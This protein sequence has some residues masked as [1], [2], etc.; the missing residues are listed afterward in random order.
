[1]NIEQGAAY[2]SQL[3]R[4]VGAVHLEAKAH[5]T[6]RIGCVLLHA[7]VRCLQCD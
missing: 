7:G 1:M 5:R 3:V 6:D 4:Y 2:I